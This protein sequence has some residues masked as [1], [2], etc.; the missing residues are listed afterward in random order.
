MNV[1]KSA[2]NWAAVRGIVM[3]CETWIHGWRDDFSCLDVDAKLLWF[4]CNWLIYSYHRGKHLQISHIP[5]RI[6]SHWPLLDLKNI[7]R[8][9]IKYNEKYSTRPRIEGEL[10][11]I[12]HIYIYNIWMRI[13][14]VHF[15]NAT[16]EGDKKI[17]RNQ[18]V[19]ATTTAH[20]QIQW[21]H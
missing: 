8:I 13:R 2:S 10:H 11:A 9:R 1:A 14:F 18:P 15:E 12:T 6:D 20:R 16:S 21:N 4:Y 3:S 19:A 7:S 17:C 5:N